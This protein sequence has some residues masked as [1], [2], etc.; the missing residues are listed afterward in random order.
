MD[1]CRLECRTWTCIASWDTATN[2]L[3]WCIVGLCSSPD[4]YLHTKRRRWPKEAGLS[5]FIRINMHTFCFLAESTHSR[6][7][8][9]LTLCLLVSRVGPGGWDESIAQYVLS[10]LQTHRVVLLGDL[11]AVSEQADFFGS[12]DDPRY[13]K[14]AC[15]TPEERKSFHE[16]LIKGCGL[17]DSFRL[18]HM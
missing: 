10:T 8:F 7:V 3:I 4:K 9:W 13:I 1:V 11:N 5:V 2:M 16:R 15:T 17:S 12:L 6:S 18:T 14:S